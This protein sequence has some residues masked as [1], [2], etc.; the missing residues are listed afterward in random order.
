MNAKRQRNQVQSNLAFINTIIPFTP[1]MD[2]RYKHSA[3]TSYKGD[4]R[5]NEPIQAEYD[6]HLEF[7]T[8]QS[9]FQL[10]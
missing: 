6:H 3:M 8:R 10:R 1:C 4:V 5:N 7:D 9:W 2:S